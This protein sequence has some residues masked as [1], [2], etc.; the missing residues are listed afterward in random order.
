MYERGD[1]V[2]VPFPFT[3]LSATRTRPAV[4]VS[5]NAFAEESR[6]MLDV[7]LHGW[8]PGRDGGMGWCQYTPSS[9][10]T[11]LESKKSDSHEH[12]RSASNA[13]QR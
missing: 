12:G 1:I 4:V 5:V 13:I 8:T 9:H 10:T 6:E 2:L 7:D 11:T 3:D